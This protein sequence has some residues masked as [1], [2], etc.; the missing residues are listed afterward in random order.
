MSKTTIPRGGITADAIDATLIADDAISEEHIDATVITGS[1]AL[2]ATPA[3]TDELLISDAGT[4]KRIDYSHIKSSPGLSFIA[5]ATTTS[6]TGTVDI[7]GCFSSSFRNYL[8]IFEYTPSSNGENPRIRFK[9][10]SNNAI[11]SSNY[12]YAFSG[13]DF[14][15]GAENSVGNND[16]S[17]IQ[18]GQGTANNENTDFPAVSGVFHILNPF[19]S[20]NNLNFMGSVLNRGN[21]GEFRQYSGAG[22]FALQTQIAGLQ[23][24][25]GSGN[26]NNANIKVYGIVDS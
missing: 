9:D 19:S 14:G 2:A 11:T 18:P 8:L 12:G 10:T 15:G 6:N 3:D 4:I 23:F 25:F 21:N 13:Q 17:A 26:V 5:S 24:F 1:T 7:N 20:S 16:D 22:R